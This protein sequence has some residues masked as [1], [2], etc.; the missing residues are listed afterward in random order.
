MKL[1]II[2]QSKNTAIV[3]DY[4]AEDIVNMMIG[5][6][7]IKK[8]ETKTNLAREVDRFLKEECEK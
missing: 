4:L 7:E 1:L 5:K 2:D 3:S 6:C 8:N